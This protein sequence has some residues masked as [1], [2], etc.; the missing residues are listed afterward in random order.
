MTEV[1]FH[2]N[3]PDKLGYA[4]R[5]LRKAAGGGAQVVVT[6]PRERLQ[7][8]DTL[9]W[10]FSQLDFVPHVLLPAEARVV[11]ASPIVLAEAA[12]EAPHR[13]VL[14]NL[15]DTVPADFECFE[16]LIEI[17]SLDDA[18]RQAARGRWKQYAEQ[19]LALTRHDLAQKGG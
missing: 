15:G 17:V 7:Q 6:A 18:D 19:G 11:A 14:L 2:F 12:A 3:V 16:R 5:L 1:A 9:L 10:T 8:L 4:C 13:Q